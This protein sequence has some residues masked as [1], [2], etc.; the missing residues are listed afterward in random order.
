MTI[1]SLFRFAWSGILACC[2]TVVCVAQDDLS[3]IGRHVSIRIT[4]FYQHWDAADTSSF[5]E[6]G[7]A[8]SVYLPLSN[9]IAVSISNTPANTAGDIS[10]PKGVTDTQLGALYHLEDAKLLFSLEMNLPTGKRELTAQEFR[11]TVLLSNLAFGMVV[12][13]FGQG[14]NIKPG[15]AWSF[16]P[17]D[18]MAVGL[19]LTYHYKGSYKPVK[20]VGDYDPGDEFLVTGGVDFTVA[21]ATNLS[22]DAIVTRYGTDVLEGSE[23]YRPGLKVVGAVQFSKYYEFNR[24]L[25]SARYRSLGKSD[26]STTFGTIE[27]GYAKVE[28]DN[29]ELQAAYTFHLSDQLNLTLGAEG[30]FYQETV[31][32]LSGAKLAGISVTP[33]LRLSPAVRIPARL[34]FQIGSVKGGKSLTGFEAA[35]GAQIDL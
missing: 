13:Q 9:A 32:P 11:N 7:V 19:G 8:L 16:T 22:V 14:F 18:D 2:F 35:L 20:G 17:R 5:A 28:P 31:A 24:L 27:K 1:Q 3:I 25:L 6:S 29:A 12:P 26:V 33:D 15:V 21:E 10:S 23:I 30:R 4:P 34:R